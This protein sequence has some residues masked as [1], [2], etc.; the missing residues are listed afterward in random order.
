MLVHREFI[1]LVFVNE[2]AEFAFSYEV[3]LCMCFVQVRIGQ[4]AIRQFAALGTV[5]V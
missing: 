4:L 3:G 1:I 2:E 5:E